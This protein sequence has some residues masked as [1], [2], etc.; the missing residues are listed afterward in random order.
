MNKPAEDAGSQSRSNQTVLTDVQVKLLA[1]LNREAVD[2]VNSRFAAARDL[3]LYDLWEHVGE[4][5]VIFRPPRWP[6]DTTPEHDRWLR[7]LQSLEL[8]LDMHVLGR[9]RAGDLL[10]FGVRLPL[11]PSTVP[12][13]IPPGLWYLVAFDMDKRTAEGNSWSYQE[14]RV[15]SLRLMVPSHRLEIATALSIIARQLESEAEA[16]DTRPTGGKG[17]PSHSHTTAA[18]TSHIDLAADRPV[19][20]AP[21]TVSGLPIAEVVLPDDSKPLRDARPG[22]WSV[23]PEIEKELRRRA[24]AVPK[25]C[26]KTWA[27][28]SHHLFKWAEKRFKRDEAKKAANP[29]SLGWL[30]QKLSDVYYELNPESERPRKPRSKS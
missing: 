17:R 4:Q 2:L 7:Q 19:A 5:E 8:K 14:V 18:R 27:L 11:R 25:E 6:A 28:E 24:A 13:P 22:P 29:P 10:A 3:N 23:M 20:P 21:D 26:L 1:G 15:I 16:S 9:L 12:T 30:R